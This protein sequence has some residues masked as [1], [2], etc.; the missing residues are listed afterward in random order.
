MAGIGERILQELDKNPVW[1]FEA[2]YLEM[3][4]EQQRDSRMRVLKAWY[5][6]EDPKN[7]VTDRW[8]FV[9]AMILFLEYYI[10]GWEENRQW[11]SLPTPEM[12]Y[13]WIWESTF[14]ITAI[15][16]YRSSG[17]STLLGRNLP[18][19]VAL[20]RPRTNLGLVLINMAMGQERGREIQRQLEENPRILADFGSQKGKRGGRTWNTRYL[21]LPNGS[22]IKIGTV[23]SAMRG[24]RPHWFILDDPEKDAEM[25]NP[26]LLA[27][28][29][30][31]LLR[32]MLPTLD[33]GRY[34][35]WIGTLIN[36]RAVLHSVIH[37]NDPQFRHWN[38]VNIKLI[39]IR[40]DGTEYS[41]WEAKYSVADSKMMQEAGSAD[42]RIKGIGRAAF[43]AE[44]QNEPVPDDQYSF[45]YDPVAHGY[46][47]MA[48]EGRLKVVSGSD[49]LDYATWLAGMRK[50]VVI[51]PAYVIGPD[52]DFTCVL[53]AGLDRTGILWALD[54]V[55]KRMTP[56]ETVQHVFRLCDTYGVE[57]VGCEAMVCSRC[58]ILSCRIR[59]IV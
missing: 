25:N 57:L 37:G 20:T 12:H 41:T 48:E 33:P 31:E 27:A 49:V 28:F 29:R 53:A 7:L 46:Y 38:K 34:F 14:P 9:R 39:Q 42:G 13:Q 36:V 52:A 1:P 4:P 22:T 50:V 6:L 45:R 26:E 11:Y 55:L 10:K 44:Y 40:E 23:K 43:M 56:T 5:D 35:T 2:G 19:F 21:E 18:M 58:I 51:D 32:V 47:V 15:A 8:A 17:K 30:R 59:C 16:A 24:G 3:S 54:Y